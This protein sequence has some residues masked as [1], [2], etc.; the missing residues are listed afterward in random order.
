MVLLVIILLSL[1][2]IY[3]TRLLSKKGMKTAS[4]MVAVLF[5]YLVA[6][7]YA[8][9]IIDIADL[10]F[11]E[12]ETRLSILHGSDVY[13]SFVD[14]NA[15]L[16][17]LSLPLLQAIVFV[18]TISIVGGFLVAFHGLFLFTKEVFEAVKNNHIFGN[19]FKKHVQKVAIIADIN[20]SQ[21]I[22]MHCRMNC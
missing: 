16:S 12:Y 1:A 4:I 5:V 15:R 7:I 6:W 19:R 8:I 17:S 2:S 18:C 11:S 22:R 20:N 14:L 9:F 21:I 13:H 3:F 10:G